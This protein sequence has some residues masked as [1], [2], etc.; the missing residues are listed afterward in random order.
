MCEHVAA[1]RAMHA[2]LTPTANRVMPPILGEGTL[3]PR[4][5][6]MMPA[7]TPLKMGRFSGWLDRRQIGPAILEWLY[8]LVHI[9]PEG[10]TNADRTFVA[11]LTALAAM[12][13][14]ETAIR[15]HAQTL[16]AR[17]EQSQLTMAHVPMH[18]D[19]W[20]GNIMRNAD[21]RL[22]I[23]DW[24]G[25]TPH[26]FAIYDLVRLAQSFGLPASR[27]GQEV[28]R[29]AS[30]MGQGP[31]GPFAHL[32]AALGHFAQHLGE[33]PRSKFVRLASECYSTLSR[34]AR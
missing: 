25:S 19:L 31:D 28:A 9:G 21:S 3:G 26:G 2:Q 23:I 15:G 17:I 7:L 29:H 33:F 34:S 13:D 12:P 14:V 22:A 16:A 32:L 30:A 5:F 1:I 24:C 4:S 11:N 20:S 8:E 6:F 18:G 27:L 10:V